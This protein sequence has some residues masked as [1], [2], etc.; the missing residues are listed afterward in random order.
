[1]CSQEASR[2]PNYF[3][4]PFGQQHSATCPVNGGRYPLGRHLKS[5]GVDPG[6]VSLLYCTGGYPGFFQEAPAIGIV[7]A[8]DI[9]VA[10]DIICYQYLPLDQPID[11]SILKLTIDELENRTHF[12][13]KG[14][15]LIPISSDSFRKALEN[16]RIDWP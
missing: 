11:L 4:I 6:D 5:Q 14:N 12:G 7:T 9:E 16:R 15:W 10:E 8:I 2:K 3:L 13:R 1:M